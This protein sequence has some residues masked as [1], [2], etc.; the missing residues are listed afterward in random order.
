MS[1]IDAL[2]TENRRFPSPAAFQRAATV[3]DTS[4]AREAAADPDA[5]WVRM[6]REL[7]WITPFTI[8][9]E[10]IRAGTDPVRSWRIAWGDSVNNPTAS[11][12]VPGSW[13]GRSHVYTAPG[14]YQYR[15]WLT[16]ASGEV[17]VNGGTVSV[18]D[19]DPFAT[20]SVTSAVASG[21]EGGPAFVYTF[22]RTGSTSLPLLIA[23]DLGASTAINGVDFTTESGTQVPLSI[24][25]AA[26]SDTATLRVLPQSDA[27]A[28]VIIASA[29]RTA[30]SASAP[31]WR[32]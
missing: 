21:P 13:L 16:D 28:E 26:G 31:R 20:V 30:W 4:L 19:N 15:V 1:E 7:E 6:A 18:F 9:L 17:E 3:S 2:L 5:Y 24:F 25:F 23:I 12:I 32:P 14:L 8:G 11:E 29:I 27:D 10:R 22:T